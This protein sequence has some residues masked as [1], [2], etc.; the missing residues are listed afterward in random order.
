MC[1]RVHVCVCV[2]SCG[3]QSFCIKIIHVF[4]PLHLV[5]VVYLWPSACT[6]SVKLFYDIKIM[7]TQLNRW[8]LHVP[9]EGSPH[10]VGLHCLTITISGSS[11][12][13]AKG[14]HLCYIQCDN[15]RLLMWF[16]FK[17]NPYLFPYS[18]FVLKDCNLV[19]SISLSAA[20]VF[21]F[22]HETHPVKRSLRFEYINLCM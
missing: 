13:F 8:L 20:A 21:S 1:V 17:Y 14:A 4:F 18:A 22:E 11:S 16:C 6:Y 10:N 12:N 15:L 9:L 7:T 19:T 5:L 3:E 2:C